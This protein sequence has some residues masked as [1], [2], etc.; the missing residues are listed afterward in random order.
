MGGRDG[1][2][3][4]PYRVYNPTLQGQR[5]DPSGDYVRRYVPELAD[6]GPAEIHEP[7][8]LPEAAREALGYPE[9]VVEHR[10]AVARFRSA[11]AEGAQ[12]ELL[13]GS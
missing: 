13:D 8:V 9:R 4:R 6:L 10:E 3:T 1:V 7:W 11:R 2:D 5:H 12:L